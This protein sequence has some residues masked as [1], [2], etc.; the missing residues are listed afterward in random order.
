MSHNPP[1]QLNDGFH[2][3]PL[4]S[5]DPNLRRGSSSSSYFDL[6]P[7]SSRS[8]GSPFSDSTSYKGYSL[9]AV[10]S[11]PDTS[12]R[13]S[14]LRGVDGSHSPDLGGSPSLSFTQSII[15][16]KD[17]ISLSLEDALGEKGNWL[18]KKPDPSNVLPDINQEK[19]NLDFSRPLSQID[20]NQQ[21]LE[22]NNGLEIPPEVPP[23]LSS[24]KRLSYAVK[25]LS[26]RITAVRAPD[27]PP[28]PK[29]D[30]SLSSNP[31]SFNP[32]TGLFD[33]S[34]ARLS[35]DN[36]LHPNT[37]SIPGPSTAYSTLDADT[38]Y[39]GAAESI[40]SRESSFYQSDNQS[41]FYNSTAN[42]VQ[43]QPLP[44]PE[45][46]LTGKSFKIFGPENKFRLLLYH[47]LRQVWVKPL[48]IFLNIFQTVILTIHN[49]RD[50]F[51]D[52][53][54][55]TNSVRFSAWYSYYVNWC[56]LAIYILYTTIVL[57]K[58][59]AYGVYDDSQRRKLE[60]AKKD[61]EESE[62]GISQPQSE[63]LPQNPG[64]RRRQ[65]R[66]NIS[67][68]KSFANLI[69]DRKGHNSNNMLEHADSLRSTTN[70]QIAP[71]RAFLRSS[72]DR[73]DFVAVISYWIS[74]FMMIGEVDTR[75]KAFIFRL[76]S[77]L[78]I[79]HLLDMTSG[80][81]SILHSLKVA[82]PLLGNVGVFVGFFW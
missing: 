72:W 34:Y 2:D 31:S 24:V 43:P 7:S 21:D 14:H 20:S 37:Y 6:R 5:L 67:V 26:N 58:C 38:S 82:G 4:Q 15:E 13:R 53:S 23:P 17:M 8:P 61:E 81:S 71:E 44:Q 32:T 66:K 70:Y 59:I 9:D 75:N 63:V 41:S 40:Y 51:A 42:I 60:K 10:N 18:T 52:V 74:L 76:L 16:D 78:P 35:N 36:S 19:L 55:T 49:A 47:T 29:R 30:N 62:I 3:I 50:I 25:A 57:S 68:V 22:A 64:L 33:K 77:A 1:S 69:P 56:Q 79:L 48:L 39:Q 45:I 46:K 80:T 65:D 27:I 73:V 28:V 54:D 12:P 11:N